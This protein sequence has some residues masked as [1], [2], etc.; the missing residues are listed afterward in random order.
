MQ[1]NHKTVLVLGGNIPHIEL[2]KK[3]KAKGYYTVLVDYLDNPPAKSVADEHVQESARDNEVVLRIAQEK[4]PEFIITLCSDRLIPAAAYASERLGLPYPL[5]YEQALDV[6]NKCRMKRLLCED[7]I[8]TSAYVTVN[9]SDKDRF[10]DD[11][12]LNYPLVLKPDDSSGSI[13]ITR[14]NDDTEL[15]DNLD[16]VI[17]LSLTRS[18]VVEEFVEGLE[19]SVDCF[20]HN[21]Q[22]E[23]LLMRS[24][25]KDPDNKDM[26]YNLVFGSII[27]SEENRALKSRIQKVAERIVAK[28]GFNNTPFFLQVFVTKQGVISVIEFGVRIGGGMTFRILETITG[29][30]VMNAA[31]DCYCGTT[32]DL[33]YEEAKHYYSTNY[34]YM[35]KGVFDEV[36]GW[37]DLQNRN[38]I[39]QFTVLGSRGREYNGVINSSNKIAFYMIKADSISNLFGKIRNSVNKIEIYNRDK[40]PLLNRDMYSMLPELETYFSGL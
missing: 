10:V 27:L 19:M 39:M 7:N 37:E 33:S 26:A 21:H 20:V 16:R 2:I 5:T 9:E 40:T 32:P 23:V 29:F 17:S 12:D 14:V 30:D 3:L 15:R 6:T 1:D 35:N 4:K 34:L 25:L 28:F 38:E 18:A 24:K 8:E 22:T 13:G 31:I 11:L 36:L